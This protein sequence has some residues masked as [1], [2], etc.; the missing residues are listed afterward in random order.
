MS[1]YRA[2]R[3]PATPGQ[4][5]LPADSA[6][7]RRP[8]DPD[9][10]GRSRGRAGRARGASV[11]VFTSPASTGSR[12]ACRARAAADQE[13]VGRA[14]RDRRQDDP[15]PGAQGPG[16][17]RHVSGTRNATKQI[18]DEAKK[19]GCEA[20][21]MAADPDR[22]RIT[23]NMMWSQEPQRVTARQSCRSTWSRTS[24]PAAARSEARRR[25]RGGHAAGPA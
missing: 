2:G 24:R 22:N 11:H 23:G 1:R 5:D 8:A 7:H 14:A 15:P 3:E 13:G 9:A 17:G 4:T 16:G 18:L 19:E 21:V 10:G 25:R 20:I 6:R 12:S